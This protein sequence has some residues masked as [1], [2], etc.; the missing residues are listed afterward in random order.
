M[1][2]CA[3]SRGAGLYDTCT[4]HLWVLTHPELVNDEGYFLCVEDPARTDVD[5]TNEENL[6]E[7][8]LKACVDRGSEC[9]AQW[10]PCRDASMLRPEFLPETDACIAGPCET[11]TDCLIDAI[12]GTSP[13]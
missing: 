8:R 3:R 9:G 10:G 13:P 2:Q 11:L 6:F 12:F 5:C 1:G 4:R 7:G